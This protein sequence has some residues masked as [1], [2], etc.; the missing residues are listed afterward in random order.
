MVK[1]YILQLK[2]WAFGAV[3]AVAFA[4]TVIGAFGQCSK[5]VGSP[6]TR[7]VDTVL[8]HRTD[9]LH[10]IDSVLKTKTKWIDTSK[11]IVIHDTFNVILPPESTE[12]ANDDT[13]IITNGQMRESLKWHDSLQSCKESRKVD[14]VALDSV[15]KL[16]KTVPDTIE[17]AP[18]LLD[19]AKD[20]G[21]GV[22]VGIGF[23]SLF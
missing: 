4:L 19:R 22:L 8:V 6:V 17:K 2:Q 15:S 1:Y 23:R 13:Q 20:F 21:V 5:P 3:V 14:S 12:I 7:Q 11:I 16:A 18:S 10:K 9:T